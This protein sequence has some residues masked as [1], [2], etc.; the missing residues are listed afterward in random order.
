MFTRIEVAW[1]HR[2]I[3]TKNDRFARLLTPG[4]HRIFGP[5]ILRI[6]M[7]THDLRSP[8]FNSKWTRFLIQNRPDLVAEHFVVAATGSLD[9]AMISVNGT[10][11]DLILPAKT[12]LFWKA[13]GKITVELVNIGAE[14]AP[15][16]MFS[17]AEL[18]T[19]SIPLD[20]TDDDWVF[21][22]QEES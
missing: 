1:N 12:V 13:A 18:Q 21:E 15:A 19:T 20:E 8:L 16:S 7:E 14:D 4:V 2:V 9:M 17:E 10:L 5:P 6:G 11:Y 3:L 22:T